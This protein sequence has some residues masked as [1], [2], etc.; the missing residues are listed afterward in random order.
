MAAPYNMS[1]FEESTN[2]L[3][4]TAAVNTQSTNL[5]VFGFLACCWFFLVALLIY[6]K[7]PPLESVTASS[8]TMML[9]SLMFLATSLIGI[10]W[11]IGFA[12]LTAAGATGLYLEKN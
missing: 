1:A 11:I 5:L 7:N 10:E 6:K 12:L 3:D 9:I 4:M 8:L 2:I